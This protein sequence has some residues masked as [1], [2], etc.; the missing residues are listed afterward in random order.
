VWEFPQDAPPEYVRHL[1]SERK[2]ATVDKRSKKTRLRWTTTGRPNHMWDAEA[3]NVLAAQILGIL[4]DMASTAPE[5]DD[6]APTE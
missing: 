1:N 2:R 6:P 3:M 4:P 5:V